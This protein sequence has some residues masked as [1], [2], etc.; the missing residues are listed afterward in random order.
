MRKAFAVFLV[1]LL[2]S[3]IGIAQYVRTF[4]PSIT[5]ATWP[6]NKSMAFTVTCDDVSSG[7]SLEYLQE[8]RSLLDSYHVRATFFVIPFHGEWD[9]MT[10]SPELVREL[11]E[12]AG[13]GHEI[14]LHGYAHYQNEFVCPPESQRELL[15]KGLDIMNQAGITVRGFRAP[16][17]QCTEETLSILKEY[18]F[19]YDSSMFGESGRPLFGGPL[20][21]LLS[22][23]EYTWYLS[24]EEYREN[25]SLA[26]KEAD[27]KFKEETVFSVVMHMK[28]VNEGEG[29][30]LMKELLAF[31]TEKNVWNCTLLELVEWETAVK[32]V[33]WDS[34]KTL[35][36]GDITF[37]NVPE[38]LSLTI[39]LPSHYASD[40]SSDDVTMTCHTD[41]KTCKVTVCFEKSYGEV[42]LPFTLS[43][44]SLQ[45]R[46]DME[47]VRGRSLDSSLSPP[48]QCLPGGMLI[49][50]EMLCLPYRNAERVKSLEELLLHPS[51][52]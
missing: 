8:I 2:A 48:C 7:Y 11:H 18:H 19:A 17:L 40:L 14:G 21:Q 44:G 39:V 12:L 1:L 16:C 22:G 4:D 20:P 9:L 38:G 27:S 15:K 6:Y 47:M 30:S 13:A 33:R 45:S 3:G 24:E 36:G 52:L 35:T 29:I 5:V 46:N 25:V 26:Q 28:A 31:V 37:Y 42:T 43:Y 34:R 32:E 50:W 49:A 51:F 23:H 10:E 41:D